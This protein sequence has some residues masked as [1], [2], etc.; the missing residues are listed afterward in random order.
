MKIL[1][2]SYLFRTKWVFLIYILIILIE[3]PETILHIRPLARHIKFG[4]CKALKKELNEK[5]MPV[6]W[7]SKKCWDCGVSEDEKKEIGPTFI[8]EL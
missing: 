2:M 3:D 6:V 1:V 5:S 7:H 4:K 8:E